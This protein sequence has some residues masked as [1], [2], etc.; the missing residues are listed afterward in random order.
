M[1]FPNGHTWD[2]PIRG[3]MVWRDRF[4]AWLCDASKA[5]VLDGMTL[6]SFSEK[7]DAV[8]LL[9]VKSNGERISVHSKIMI[10]ADGGSSSIVKSLQPAL[11]A[12][13]T[14]YFALQE[15]YACRC[16][17]EPGYFHFFCIPEISLYSSSYIKDGLLIM[18]VVIG[19]ADKATSAMSRFKNFLWE[20]I[21]IKEVCLIRRLG[22]KVTYAAQK[23]LFCFG[24][25]R[26]LV[27]GEAS[28]LLNL[29]GEGISSALASGIIAGRASVCGMQENITPGRLYRQEI[30]E[31]RRKTLRTFDYRRLLFMEGGAFN[32]KEGLDSLMWKDRVVFF[33]NLLKWI[34]TLRRRLSFQN[35]PSKGR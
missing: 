33:W 11:V 28:G 23:E 10:A 3:L 5:E 6:K 35:P 21:D 24:T 20:K 31:E 4:D 16:N 22:C 9:C 13:S 8:D 7:N 19:A 2:I 12:K 29:F 14:W 26:I 27:C 18:D 17:L 34:F 25:D 1:Y 32:F 30:E 15:T